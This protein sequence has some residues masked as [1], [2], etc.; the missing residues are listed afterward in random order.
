MP[1]YIHGATAD[2]IANKNGQC[3]LIVSIYHALVAE[4]AQSLTS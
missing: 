3:D 1:A 4:D 2:I